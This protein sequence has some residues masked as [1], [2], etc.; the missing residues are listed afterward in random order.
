MYFKPTY[1]FI[2]LFIFLAMGITLSIN[3]GD[4]PI[5]IFKPLDA[6][7]QQIL[8]DLRLPRIMMAICIGML[9]GASGVITQN[10]FNNPIADPY[11]IGIAQA[12][13]LGSVIAYMMGFSDVWYGIFGFIFCASF[14]LL[15]FG[16]GR[17]NSLATLLIIGISL[18]SFLGAFSSFA[19]YLIGEQSFKIVIWLMGYL[20]NASWFRVGI[21][22]AAVLVVCL[23]FYSKRHDLNIMLCGDIE[24]QSLGIN[25][26]KT[27]KRLLLVCAFGVGFGIAFSGLIGFIGLIV[28]HFFRLILKNT[29]NTILLPLSALGGGIF[30]LFSD[31]LART[32]LAPTEIPIGVITS[33]L[34]APLFLYL[35]LKQQGKF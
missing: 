27:K 13:T 22:A 18:S 26:E 29:N 4:L 25:V 14:C 28:P 12:A 21:L 24:A 9:L 10:I 32:I 17:N 31:S 15:L 34:G 16:I 2:I 35:A 7:Q 11:V 23:Y 1:M 6:L 8:I 20:G 30:L 33:F 5:N 19:M 3:I